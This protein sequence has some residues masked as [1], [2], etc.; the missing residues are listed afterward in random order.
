MGDL[1]LLMQEEE[2]LKEQME[3][4]KVALAEN[5]EKQNKIKLSLQ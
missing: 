4:L 1:S 3:L 2:K 5:E